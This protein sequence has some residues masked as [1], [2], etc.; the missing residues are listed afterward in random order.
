MSFCSNSTNLTKLKA[1]RADSFNLFYHKKTSKI[2]LTF[3]TD[4]A[5]GVWGF[6]VLGFGICGSGYVCGTLC[7]SVV[8]KFSTQMEGLITL[9]LHIMFRFI[10]L[11]Y[12]SSFINAEFTAQLRFPI[13]LSPSQHLTFLFLALP[14]I[15]SIITATEMLI[16]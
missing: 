15:H 8:Q 9:T 12:Y 2:H 13:S 1:A 5:I 6:G 3:T 14:K 11:H 16:I 4:V 7:I 10:N